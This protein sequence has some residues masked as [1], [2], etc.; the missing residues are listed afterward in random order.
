LQF[1]ESINTEYDKITG[2]KIVKERL[3]IIDNSILWITGFVQFQYEGKDKIIQPG[4]NA[5]KSALMI[6]DSIIINPSEPLLN[7]Y[8]TLR[9]PLT[10]LEYALSKF[11]IKTNQ[12][13]AVLREG[14]R[15]LK[16]RDK[17]KD[18]IVKQK[19]NENGKFSGNFKAQGEELFAERNKRYIAKDE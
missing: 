18:N 2:K 19:K 3:V 8:S 17:D 16:D 1:T 6:L 14:F 9:Q 10:V 13:L 7:P 5:I 12:P 4:A 11:H 15:T